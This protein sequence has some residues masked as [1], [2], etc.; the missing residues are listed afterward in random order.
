MSR[1]IDEQL[2]DVF[3]FVRSMC[4]HRCFMVQTMSQYIFIHDALLEV[5]ECGTTEVA[6]RDLPSQ[7]KLLQT[8]DEKTGKTLLELELQVGRRG[9]GLASVHTVHFVFDTS[10]NSP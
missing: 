10:D 9:R 3:S 2:I 5:L 6:A 7:Y 4:L 1:I 8:M